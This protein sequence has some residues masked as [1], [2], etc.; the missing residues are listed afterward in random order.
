M[1]SHTDKEVGG[2]YGLECVNLARVKFTALNLPSYVF[3]IR[4]AVMKILGRFEW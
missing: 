4:M 2:L 3:R 1:I